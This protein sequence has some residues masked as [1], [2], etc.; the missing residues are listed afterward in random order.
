MANSTPDEKSQRLSCE[1]RMGS[2]STLA[3]SLFVY[4]VSYWEDTVTCAF[5]IAQLCYAFSGYMCTKCDSTGG[6]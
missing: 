1:N 6:Y 4:F 5:G 2:S 3:V